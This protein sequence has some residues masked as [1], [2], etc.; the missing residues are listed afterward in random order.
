MATLELSQ[1]TIAGC[2]RQYGA[3]LQSGQVVIFHGGTP[4]LRRLFLEVVGG[5]ALPERGFVSLD[6]KSFADMKP[7]ARRKLSRSQF[8]YMAGNDLLLEYLT[9]VENCLVPEPNV[10]GISIE[11]TKILLRNLGISSPDLRFPN[12]LSPLER[13]LVNLARAVRLDPQVLLAYEPS[14]G[15]NDQEVSAFY[16][17]M[18]NLAPTRNL[19]VVAVEDA[20]PQCLKPLDIVT[21]SLEGSEQPEPAEKED[22][23]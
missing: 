9:A 10:T 7:E 12:Q 15:L 13:K 6:D 22:L 17:A 11:R 21:F 20:A 14:L 8:R 18:Q 1:V 2:N 3:K 4:A 23:L 5:Q 16:T 19:L